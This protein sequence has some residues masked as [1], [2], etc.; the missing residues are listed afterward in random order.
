MVEKSE[1]CTSCGIRLVGKGKTVF[2]CPSCGNVS[3]G[4]CPQCRDQ[5]VK[6]KCRECGF[7]GP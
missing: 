1:I 2:L 7:I 3:I 5:S 6:Y 4:R